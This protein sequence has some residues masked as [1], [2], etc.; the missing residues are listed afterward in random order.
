MTTLCISVPVKLLTDCLCPQIWDMTQV[1]GC[2]LATGFSSRWLALPATWSLWWP[3]L[4][5]QCH[6]NPF[7]QSTS[8]SRLG[9]AATTGPAKGECVSPPHSSHNSHQCQSYKTALT[10]STITMWV[11]VCMYVYNTHFSYG[12]DAIDISV[13][14]TLFPKL[15]LTF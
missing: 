6:G 15:L 1:V 2:S 11:C 8:P 14:I 12:R 9:S 10:R 13:Y 4:L 5:F 7:V 3:R